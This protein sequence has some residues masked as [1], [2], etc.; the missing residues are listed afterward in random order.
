[1]VTKRVVV[2]FESPTLKGEKMFNI[3]Y[4]VDQ[5]W[6]GSYACV[7]PICNQTLCILVND[8]IYLLA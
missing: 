2:I 5:E 3:F 8:T 4:R 1:M 6:P 7:G